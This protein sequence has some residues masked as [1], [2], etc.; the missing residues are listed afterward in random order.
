MSFTSSPVIVA[1]TESPPSYYLENLFL[2]NLS[3][4]S[5]TCLV[6]PRTNVAHHCHDDLSVVLRRIACASNSSRLRIENLDLQPSW[7]TQLPVLPHPVSLDVLQSQGS[8]QT[9]LLRM[10]I[11]PLV[12]EQ[13]SMEQGDPL[14]SS[15]SHKL[16]LVESTL[17]YAFQSQLE[18]NF[19]WL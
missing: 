9:L 8:D 15:S 16:W 14:S 17:V 18:L 4:H 12:M 5:Q 11:S 6:V 1:T 13:L 10:N 19:K 2:F 7:G 3:P